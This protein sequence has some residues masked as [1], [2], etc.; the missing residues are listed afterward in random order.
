MEEVIGPEIYS[1]PIQHG[2]L[3]LPESRAIRDAEGNILQGAT[4]WHQ[5][6]GVT[7]PEADETDMIT[8]WFPLWDAP[9]ESGCLEVIPRSHR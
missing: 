2:R 9:I 1:N 8:V 6:N 5:D 4:P 7:Q 3:K